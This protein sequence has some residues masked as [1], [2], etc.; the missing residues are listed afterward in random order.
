M[1]THPDA[2][3]WQPL[4][5]RLVPVIG[6]LLIFL[7]GY[8]QTLSWTRYTQGSNDEIAQR[9]AYDAAG[10]MYVVGYYAG[11]TTF[12]PWVGSPSLTSAGSNDDVLYLDDARSTGVRSDG[13]L[14]W[15]PWLR[16]G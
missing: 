10:N 1:Q 4:L 2:R 11:S 16:R 5:R 13:N 6:L 7:P 12:G 3:S 8:A 9:T 14:R 15:T